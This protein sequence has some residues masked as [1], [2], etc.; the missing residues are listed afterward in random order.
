MSDLDID[1]NT[2]SWECKD[3]KFIDPSAGHVVTGNLKIMPDFRIRY[4]VSKGPNYRFPFHIDF[5]RWR[6]E[7]AAALNVLLIDGVKE[8]VLS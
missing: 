7:I 4:I 8:R 6:E 3:S 1:A 2:D 5:N